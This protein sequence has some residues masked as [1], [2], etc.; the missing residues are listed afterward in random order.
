[1]GILMPAVFFGHGSPMNSL[2][3][4]IYTESWRRFGQSIP[5]PKAILALS[6]H[7]Y[8]QG[9]AVTGVTFPETIHDFGGF[10]RQLYEVSSLC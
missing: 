3:T 5:R 4:N 7:W 2:Q 8:I 10:P 6:A 9:S 1:M